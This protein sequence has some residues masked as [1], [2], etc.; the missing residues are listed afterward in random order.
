VSGVWP[1]VVAAQDQLQAEKRMT[2]AKMLTT[3]GFLLGLL[4]V[5]SLAH[6]SQT[7]LPSSPPECIATALGDI[8]SC[9]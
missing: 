1:C 6:S 5:A 3:V 8:A 4:A 7:G 9:N 2:M